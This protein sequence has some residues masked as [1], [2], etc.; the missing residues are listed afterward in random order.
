MNRRKF[1]LTGGLMCSA[2]LA[3]CLGNGDDDPEEQLPNEQTDE[4]GDDEGT[5]NG[6]EEDDS[7]DFGDGEAPG[8]TV[9]PYDQDFSLAY[10]VE[11]LSNETEESPLT[12]QISLTNPSDDTIYEYSERRSAMFWLAD[13]DAD[14]E[15]YPAEG[16]ESNLVY[17]ESTEGWGL[18]EEFVMTMD[19]QIETIEPQETHTETIVVVNGADS[20]TL[21]PIEDAEEVEVSNEFNIV[22]HDDA[23]SD[24]FS[25]GEI[26]EWGFTLL[27]E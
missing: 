2:G 19:Y 10:S 1:V 15:T 4:N 5:E 16:V 23:D 7:M 14:F 11:I 9:D 17:D 21:T 27:F 18:E 13:V 26:S 6:E 8:V 22:D 3:G 12:L 20:T 24:G 25:S